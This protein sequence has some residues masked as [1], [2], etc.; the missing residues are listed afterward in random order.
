[1]TVFLLNFVPF[2]SATSFNSGIEFNKYP[3]FNREAFN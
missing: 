1:M 2:I 3:W